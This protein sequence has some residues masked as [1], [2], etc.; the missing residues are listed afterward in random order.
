MRRPA[1]V[2][3]VLLAVMIGAWPGAQTFAADEPKQEFGSRTA[4][5]L[6]VS[7]ETQP[8][9]PSSSGAGSP[10]RTGQRGARCTMLRKR[11]ARS[12][13]CFN[14]YRMKN[15]GLRSGAFQRCEQLKDP[16]SECGPVVGR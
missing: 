14:R 13:A 15:H 8:A 3:H 6:G 4:T 7:P 2:L 9:P 1:L 5:G 12:E 10:S 16:S 11:Y